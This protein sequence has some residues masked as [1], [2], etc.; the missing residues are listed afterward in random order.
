MLSTGIDMLNRGGPVMWVLLAMSIA[1]LAI[2]AAKFYQFAQLKLGKRDFVDQ[3][4]QA[5]RAGDERKADQILKKSKNPVARVLEVA[6]TTASN[7]RLTPEDRDAQVGSCGVQQIAEMNTQ[8]RT[9]ELLGNLA[10]LVGLLGTVSGMIQAFAQLELAGSQVDPSL[11]AGG[12]WE[13]LLT[14]AFGLTVAIPAVAAFQL[15]DARIE[16]TRTQMR[17]A[18]VGVLEI[19]HEQEHQAGTMPAAAATA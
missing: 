4:L 9:L 17:N 14:T 6:K 12:I 11:L 16:R 18:A 10:P 15:F 8:L 5:L 3:A 7:P 1:A 13:A 2:I 19:Y